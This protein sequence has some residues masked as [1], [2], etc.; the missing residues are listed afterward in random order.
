[1]N[2]SVPCWEKGSRMAIFPT[3]R[4]DD[5]LKHPLIWLVSGC[6]VDFP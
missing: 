2:F 6:L 1:M 4:N 5:Q 3:K